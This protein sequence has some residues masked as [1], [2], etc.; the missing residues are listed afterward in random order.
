M[1]LILDKFYVH[2]KNLLDP[3]DLVP[4]GIPYIIHRTSFIRNQLFVFLSFV[5]KF[6]AQL[7]LL[8]HEEQFPCVCQESQE[9]LHMAIETH[10]RDWILYRDYTI[11]SV[12]GSKINPSILPT[13]LTPRIFALDIL[14]KSFDY[15]Y[16]HFS[17]KNH[18]AY[19]KLPITTGPFTTKNRSEVQLIEDMLTYFIFEIDGSCQYDPAR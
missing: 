2:F 15:D 12:Y 9:C 19:F 7:Y 18:V 6:I 5:E 13:F 8:I 1:Y 14:R 10:V 17:K 3:Q 4:Y 16:L 11:I